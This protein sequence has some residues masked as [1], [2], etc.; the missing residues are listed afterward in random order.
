MA[1]AL[2]LADVLGRI[3][4]AITQQATATD[5]LEARVTLGDT[6]VQGVVMALEGRLADSEKKLADALQ[7]VSNTMISMQT[8]L[9]A[10]TPAPM[11]PP[12]LAVP[13]VAKATGQT[14]GSLQFDPWENKTPV[15]GQ[16]G[17]SPN[18]A[19]PRPQ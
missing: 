8:G 7:A 11:T 2:G 1:E 17:F 3:E 16:Q 10:Q 19:R 5:A 15:A 13:N 18:L 14:E 12:G 6:N 9:A 4:A